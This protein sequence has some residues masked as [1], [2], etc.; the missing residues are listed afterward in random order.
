MPFHSI[1]HVG[2]ELLPGVTL[3]VD[4][5]TPGCGGVP[6]LSL[7]GDV[8]DEF[9][10]ADDSTTLLE[11]M[12]A[13]E[14]HRFRGVLEKGDK[15]LGWTV[16]RVPFEPGEVWGEMVR[17]RVAGE[18]NGFGFRTSLFPDVRG[19]FCLLVNKAVQRGAGIQVG[20]AAEFRLWPDLEERA[21]ELPDELAV[22]LEEGDG[23]LAWYD[24]LTEYTR[25]EIGKW[26]LGVKGEE[27]R[28]RRATQ[29]AERLLATMEAERELPPLIA[30]A[31]KRRPKAKA[32]WERMTEAQRRGH[33]MGVFYYQTPESR[34]KRVGKLVEEAEKRG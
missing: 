26:V 33:L 9:Y 17:L 23:L 24:G 8:E 7:L 16:V 18:V 15:A 28:V 4:S 5:L 13:D 6:A 14:G 22:L 30:V 10:H 27:A 11:T 32:G 20:D 2:T 21:A 29:M 31:L 1:L 3:S 19:G 25:R 34:E 12:M